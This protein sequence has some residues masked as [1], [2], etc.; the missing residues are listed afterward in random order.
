MARNDDLSKTMRI[1]LIPDAGAPDSGGPKARVSSLTRMNW[2]ATAARKVPAYAAKSDYHKLLQSLYDAALVTTLTGKITDVNVRATE[3]LQYERKEL[4]ELSVSQIISGANEQ[5][6]ETLLT[7]LENERFTLL[8][9]Y[10]VRRDRSF[11]PAEI[12]VNKLQLEEPLLCFFVRDITVR[13]QAEERLR[14][15]HKAIQITGNGIAIAD[16]D[17]RLDY[18]N[19][20]FAIMLG[21]AETEPL[22]GRDIRDFIND[23]VAADELVDKVKGD[24]RTWMSEMSMKTKDGGDLFVQVSATCNRSSEGEALGIVFSFADITD[25]K[26]A[27]EKLD[28]MQMEMDKKVAEK[29]TALAK[30][31]RELEAEIAGLKAARE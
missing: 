25:Y 9:A 16:L 8:Q 13:R 19:P 24:Q 27:Q 22:L 7:N 31:S 26:Q 21:Y 1:D 10:C 28:T 29:T 12:A 18:A 2:T 23:T 11:F 17:A 14:T 6:I 20:A 5:L 4:R 15:E 30:H 3:F